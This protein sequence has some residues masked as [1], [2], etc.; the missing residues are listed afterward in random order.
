MGQ[1]SSARIST[2]RLAGLGR[3]S[4]AL[5]AF[6]CLALVAGFIPA[7]QAAAA[8]SKQTAAATD[9]PS[10]TSPT[11][12]QNVPEALRAEIEKAIGASHPKIA[13]TAGSHQALWD[14]N[15]KLAASFSVDGA[16][17]SGSGDQFSVG[18]GSIGRS[19]P[20]EAIASDL[21]RGKPVPPMD[22]ATSQSRSSRPRMGSSRVSISR[23]AQLVPGLW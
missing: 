5:M 1:A 4:C 22:Q 3:A 19:A 7:Q 18:R 17:F 8:G 16:Q 23:I 10:T 12:L 20:T 14:R 9:P 21:T 13:P 11:T 2:S 6:I 15:H